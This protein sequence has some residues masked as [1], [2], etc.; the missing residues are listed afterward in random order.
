M[1]KRFS[2]EIFRNL[3]YKKSLRKMISHSP[4]EE[5]YNH[6]FQLKSAIEPEI[7][8]YTNY[9]YDF[10]GMIDYIFYPQKTMKPTGYLGPMDASWLKENKV[11]GCPHP[12]LPSGMYDKN[13]LIRFL[14]ASYEE[15]QSW[16]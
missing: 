2:F 4:D 3:A 13:T 7:M 8:P 5:M 6:G 12:H 11:I 14:T 10:K 15:S 9:T 16:E 1:I